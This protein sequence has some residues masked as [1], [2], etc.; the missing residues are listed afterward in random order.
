VEHD[1]LRALVPAYA[2][3]GLDAEAATCVR[4][5]L[6]TGCTECL[7]A[8]FAPRPPPVAASRPAPR[9]ARISWAR[10]LLVAV[11]LAGVASIVTVTARTLADVRRRATVLG[12]EADALG[13]R[14]RDAEQASAALGE[15]VGRL[16][17]ELRAARAE[18]GRHRRES[19]RQARA[20]R[21][22]TA[23]ERELRHALDLAEAR[24]S[25]LVR[26]LRRR[27]VEIERL[28]DGLT[29]GRALRALVA[30]PGVTM[31]PLAP[32]RPFRDVRGH[33]LWHPARPDMLLYAF[34]LPPP[35]GGVEYRARVTLADGR[36]AVGPAL[37]PDARGDA[38]RVMPLATDGGGP[39][40]FEVILH[41]AATAVLVGQAR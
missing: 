17:A 29:E 32:A 31:T 23:A 35:P 12:A 40:R 22:G 24:I 16:V 37:R 39:R 13:R 18:S 2:A 19:R 1:E 33:V 9:R 10:A 7:D 14:A 4:A 21:A 11:A 36:V 8:V 27:D 25:T 20:V 26:G 41:P 15:R 6:A 38:T 30:T 3:G 34:A 28:L 5:H